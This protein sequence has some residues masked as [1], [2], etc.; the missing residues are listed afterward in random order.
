LKR[1]LLVFISFFLFK[2]LYSIIKRN[3]EGK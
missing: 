1:K 2:I 3:D